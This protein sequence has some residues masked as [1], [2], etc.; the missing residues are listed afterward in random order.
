MILGR[1]AYK[2]TKQNW[3]LPVRSEAK[4]NVRR[5]V[6]DISFVVG[7][8]SRDRLKMIHLL[9]G[10]CEIAEEITRSLTSP[11]RRPSRRR[12]WPNR[13]GTNQV[14]LAAIGHA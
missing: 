2:R 14:E 1:M 3:L 4:A 8:Q 7:K 5:F 11:C 10:H 12:R 9:R 6:D 13:G